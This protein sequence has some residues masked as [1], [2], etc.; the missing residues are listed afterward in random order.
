MDTDDASRVA[1]DGVCPFVLVVCVVGP[2]S[3]DI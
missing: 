1:T 2:Q 3:L